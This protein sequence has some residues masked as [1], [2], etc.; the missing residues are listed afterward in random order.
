MPVPHRD[1]PL[2]LHV[3]RR[4]APNLAQCRANPGILLP[5]RSNSLGYANAEDIPRLGDDWTALFNAD[6]KRP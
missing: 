5:V 4:P 3:A 6:L 1:G 2:G